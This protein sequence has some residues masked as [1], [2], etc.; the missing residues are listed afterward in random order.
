M[1]YQ[2]SRPPPPPPPRLP[3]S[4]GHSWP[5]PRASRGAGTSW[6]GGGLQG[7]PVMGQ[8]EAGQ[9]EALRP[10]G[11]EEDIWEVWGFGAGGGTWRQGQST[12]EAQSW[13][14]GIHQAPPVCGTRRGRG[15]PGTPTQASRSEVVHP[16]GI[17]QPPTVITG[18]SGETTQ[19]RGTAPS[20][21]HSWAL[22][23]G[24][25]GAPAAL[26]RASHPPR[27]SRDTPQTASRLPAQS[28]P[29][30][31]GVQPLSATRPA[32]AGASA[33]LP[34]VGPPSPAESGR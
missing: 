9:A 5:N 10:W 26:G 24:P 21:G 16:R 19:Q 30:R 4:T 18:S 7:W 22:D 25:L 34:R 8:R 12:E 14:F 3:T 33:P 6:A 31:A 29:D 27:P 20:C 28:P 11:E 32:R 23:K 13:S 17:A 15:S 1:S 2:R